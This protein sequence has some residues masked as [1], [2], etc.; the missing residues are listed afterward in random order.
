MSCMEPEH[1]NIYTQE[2]PGTFPFSWVML[3]TVA[4]ASALHLVSYI[5]GFDKINLMS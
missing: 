2:Q 5:G 4:L 1:V 3:T